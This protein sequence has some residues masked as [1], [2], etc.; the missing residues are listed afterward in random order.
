MN[1]RRLFLIGGV[2]AVGAGAS[3][4]FWPRIQRNAANAER[5][6]A[7][8]RAV[9]GIDK[10]STK[11]KL[12]ELGMAGFVAFWNA[13]V[14]RRL[15]RARNPLI[16]P[17]Q[18]LLAAGTL[19]RDPA[20]AEQIDQLQGRLGLTLPESLRAFYLA[21]NG[22]RSLWGGVEAHND[23]LPVN[24]V[25][26]LRERDPELIRIWQTT[27]YNTTPERYADYGPN[28]DPV[29]IRTDYM[30]KMICLTPILD[31]GGLFLNSALR[32]PSGELEAWDFSVKN[33]GAYRT[34]TLGELL[35]KVCER[36][37]F[38]LDVESATFDLRPAVR[39]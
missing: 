11:G 26:W 14:M 33:P 30:D 3:V 5:A 25:N 1:K 27:A 31:G 38:G 13:E 21:S 16:P 15:R 9:A 12:A 8:R 36:D 2:V 17:Q 35:E 29:H 37:C 7:Y 19:L 20:T 28:Q 6:E 23:F 39:N 18:S 32:F 10:L 34:R 24:E 4:V 22:L